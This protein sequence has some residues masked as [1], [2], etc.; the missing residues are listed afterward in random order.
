MKYKVEKDDPY[1]YGY[2]WDES[3]QRWC[4]IK[5][6]ISLTKLGCKYFAKKIS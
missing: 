5:N 1:W 3:I 2:K 6:S 4:Y